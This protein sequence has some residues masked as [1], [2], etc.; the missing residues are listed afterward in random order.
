MPSPAVITDTQMDPDEAIR[1]IWGANLSE[2]M[3]LL[4]VTNKALVGA[5]KAHGVDVSQQAVGQWRAGQNAPRPHVMVAICTVLR[6]PPRV[7]FSLD[8]IRVAA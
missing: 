8:L 5:L 6:V 2:Q 7:L 1:L 4:G 3:R